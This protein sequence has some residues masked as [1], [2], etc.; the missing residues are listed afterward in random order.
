MKSTTNKFHWLPELDESAVKFSH[1]EIMAK[2][3]ATIDPQGYPHITMI[4]SN[5]A[6]SPSVLKWGEF[7][8]GQSKSNVVKNPKQGFL[9]MTAEMPFQFLQVKG[10]LESISTDGED[11]ADFNQ[12]SLF[13]YNTYMRIYRTFFNRIIQARKIRNISLF[14]IVRGILANLNPFQFKAKT[15]DYEERLEPVG[16]RLFS[17]PIFPKFISYIDTDGYPVIIPCFQ[18]RTVEGKRIRIPLTQFKD[19]L[20]QIPKDSKVAMFAMDFEMVTQLIKG[21]FLGI[22]RKTGIVDIERV[23]NSMPPKM[24]E[25]YPNKVKVEKV[26]EFPAIL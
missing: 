3:V 12:I 17:G 19:D 22:Q 1:I 11:A 26:E 5:K 8:T 10:E 15:G 20:L 7:T 23:Y 14:G 24:G 6:T 2:F 21:R 25:I 9:Y 4:T 13:R 18:A 16:I